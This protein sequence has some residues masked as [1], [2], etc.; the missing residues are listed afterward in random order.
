M[1]FYTSVAA[2]LKSGQSNR[3]KTLK[4]AN[5]DILRFALPWFCGSLFL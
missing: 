1:K 3:K 4:K 5:I 2:G